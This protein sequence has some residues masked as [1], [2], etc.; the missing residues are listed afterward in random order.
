MSNRL[1]ISM[2]LLVL[3]GMAILLGLNLTAIFSG[4]RPSNAYLDPNKVRGIAVRHNQLL[5]TLNFSQQNEV[6]NFI[7]RSNPI[8]EIIP[9]KRQ[10]PNVDKIIIYQFGGAEDLIITPIAYVNNNLIYST[11]QWN[12]NGYL[13]DV[14]EGKL[15]KL[16]SQTYDP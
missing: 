9:G 7:N 12:P 11:P 15:Q 5:Y 10:N 2:T 4:N 3:L 14:S 8:A 13:M 6:I 1:L 16:L